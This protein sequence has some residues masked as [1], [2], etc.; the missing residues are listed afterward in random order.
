MLV[1][2]DPD[3]SKPDAISVGLIDSLTNVQGRCTRKSASATDIEAQSATEPD[4]GEGQI[5]EDVEMTLNEIFAKHPELK[6]EVQALV[7]EAVNAVELKSKKISAYVSSKHAAVRD[8]AQKVL[9]GESSIDALEGAVTVLDA[10]EAAQTIENAQAEE[11]EAT[12]TEPIAPPAEDPKV[13]ETGVC[14][15][16]E[17]FEALLA[18]EE[19][20]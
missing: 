10:M 13:L 16:N 9:A 3:E 15:T 11:P 18:D 8:L 12:P 4:N 20:K 2:Q 19:A 5:Q 14:E 6:T 17:D 7:N 1:A